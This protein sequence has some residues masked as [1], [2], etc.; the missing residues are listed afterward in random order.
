MSSWI[1]M[2]IIALSHRKLPQ[3][4]NELATGNTSY[5]AWS[6]VQRRALPFHRV[7][8]CCRGHYIC[9]CPTVRGNKS[10]YFL[11]IFSQPPYS[12]CCCLW[13]RSS[14]IAESSH[15][16]PHSGKFKSFS[17][18]ILL[19]L[20]K[21]ALKLIW[22]CLCLW[23]ACFARSVVVGVPRGSVPRTRWSRLSLSLT[24]RFRRWHDG[25]RGQS[26]A[27]P[28]LWSPCPGCSR[29]LCLC[30]SRDVCSAAPRCG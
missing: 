9:W 25:S 12:Y 18:S 5:G 1:P 10:S 17:N 24:R 2:I 4:L 16:L 27:P 11:R 26:S 3:R 22:F 21:T 8:V 19:E 6:P 7:P 30:L 20:L 13:Y 14:T 28:S 23:T 15:L 29:D